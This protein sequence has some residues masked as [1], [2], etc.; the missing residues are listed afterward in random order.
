MLFL[1]ILAVGVYTREWVTQ[2]KSP[3]GGVIWWALPITDVPLNRAAN[4][5]G[6]LDS[7]FWHGT[8]TTS[9][10]PAHTDRSYRILSAQDTQYL[11]T[12]SFAFSEFAG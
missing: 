8:I 3:G 2:D 4:T 9:V 1:V 7:K 10:P 12:H 6:S 5:S 11:L